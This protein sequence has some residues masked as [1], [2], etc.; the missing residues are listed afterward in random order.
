[1]IRSERAPAPAASSPLRAPCAGAVRGASVALLC[2]AALTPLAASAAP[3][4]DVVLRNGTVLEDVEYEVRGESVRVTLKYGSR[5]YRRD[6][7]RRL[8]PKDAPSSTDGA[9]EDGGP[10]AA[11]WETR[12]R[13]QELA[14]WE[15]VAANDPLVRARMKHTQRDALLE[16]R[17]R[18]ADSAWNIPEPGARARVDRS[19]SDEIFADLATRFARRPRGTVTPFAYQ[20]SRV[21]RVGPFTALPHGSE[22]GEER[23]ITELR[24][25]NHGLEYA[26]SCSVKSEDAA[27]LAD[28]VEVALRAFSFLPVLDLDEDH[29]AD[30]THGFRLRRPGDDWILETEPFSTTKPLR[31]RNKDGRAVV[32]VRVLPGRPDEAVA[33]LLEERKKRSRYF[34]ERAREARTHRGSS[35]VAFEFED[36]EPGGRRKLHYQGFGG[37]AAGHTV[38]V[39]GM[40]PLSDEDAA[41]L[42]REVRAV[43]ESVQ[44]YDQERARRRLGE[45]A[46]ALRAVAS[47]WAAALKRDWSKALRDYDTAI[48]EMPT[49]A[50]AHYLRGLA[51]KELGDAK[52]YAED[53]EK[54]AALDPAGGY[55]AALGD[56]ARTEAE[57]ATRKKD[58]RRALELWARVYASSKNEKDLRDLLRAGTSYWGQQRR[59]PRLRDTVRAFEKALKPVR[60]VKGVHELLARVYREAGAELLRK[61]EYSDARRMASALRKLGRIVKAK[62]YE[63]DAGRLSDQI[64]RARGD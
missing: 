29:Y 4:G 17:V 20:G 10:S 22:R 12:F 64:K 41:K 54:A 11:D 59:K 57:I 35:V 32:L 52:G 34:V 33:A 40:A 39:Q 7:I 18:P 13:L 31:A 38:L 46:R 3:R 60:K 30:Y 9:T 19:V 62:R 61:K 37:F 5:T 25:R 50:L 27:V 26:V 63:S 51:K 55:D 48:G 1:M 58:W 43:I 16:V 47:G 36:F 2:A 44:L 49:Y 45:E 42:D 23:T 56:L 28:E 21:Y 8:V 14:D 15:P 6:E 53:V 24:F